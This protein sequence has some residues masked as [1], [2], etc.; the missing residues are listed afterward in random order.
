MV[1]PRHVLCDLF[2]IFDIV[3]RDAV[4]CGLDGCRTILSKTYVCT[5]PHALGYRSLLSLTLHHACGVLVVEVCAV[6]L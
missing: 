5:S 1:L 4:E 3:D 2:C 6:I